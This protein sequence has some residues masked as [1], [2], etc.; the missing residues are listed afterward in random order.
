MDKYNDFVNGKLSA[1]DI[2]T[3]QTLNKRLRDVE[4]K[5]ER[6]V[7]L[8]DSQANALMLDN[9]NP[10]QDYEINIKIDC[11]M[12]EKSQYYDEEDGD[13]EILITSESLWG[14]PF[15]LPFNF[16]LMSDTNFNGCVDIK[17]HPLEGEFHC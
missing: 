15:D 4:M 11:C 8:L 13:S 17:R 14:K 12:S 3:L 2:A 1:D 16:G 7:P 10:I 9:T 5:A 6:T